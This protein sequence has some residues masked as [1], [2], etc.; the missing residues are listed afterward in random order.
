MR[1]RTPPGFTLIEM[2][3]V[4]AI[5]GVL[6]A[7][8]LPAVQA[9]RESARRTQCENNLKQLG[10]AFHNHHDSQ[11]VFPAIK[12]DPRDTS[13]VSTTLPA[14]AW[15]TDLLP[16]LEQEPIRKAYQINNAYDYT[17]GVTTTVDNLDVITNVIKVFQCASSPIQNRTAAIY[18][19]DTALTATPVAVT[20]AKTGGAVDY[21][22]HLLITSEDLTVTRNPALQ[23]N[24]QEPMSAILDG[25]SQT[26]LLD[27]VAMRPTKYIN[28]YKQTT[29]VA[30]PDWAV[31]GGFAAT[32]LYMYNTDGTVNTTT[33]LTAA[34]AVNCNND[35]GIYAFHPAG[36]NALFCD[37]SV[38]FLSRATTATVIL[39]L[40]TR[41]GNE[42]VP[43]NAY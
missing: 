9:A 27:E 11:R 4:I 38:R 3:V 43:P 36:A 42:I 29:N 1:S 30:S 12:T 22:P 41:D 18:K 21:Y 32:N 6:M 37:G 20:P 5:I 26:I 14:H 33:P 13:N 39:S 28:G 35:A 34:C 40:A 17:D 10:L 25:T 8:L 23:I 24:K 31:W 7:L 2:L 16:Y 19:S 15:C